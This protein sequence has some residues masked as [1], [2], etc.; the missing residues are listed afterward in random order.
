MNTS[1]EIFQ[2]MEIGFSLFIVGVDNS[3]IYTRSIDQKFKIDVI[4]WNLK[5]VHVFKILIPK[6][7]FF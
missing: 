4:D 3:F 2:Q 5:Y 1:L 6:K 7:N